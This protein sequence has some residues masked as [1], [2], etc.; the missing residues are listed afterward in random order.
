MTIENAGDQTN[1]DHIK[2]ATQENT[3]EDQEI[4]QLIFK[5]A[6]DRTEIKIL[7]L[8]NI[9]V[10]FKK[11]LNGSFYDR[12]I[13]TDFYNL[14]SY[15]QE[16]IYSIQKVLQAAQTILLIF[17]LYGQE[18]LLYL[19][20]H[21]QYLNYIPTFKEILD[22]TIE[23]KRYFSMYLLHHFIMKGADFEE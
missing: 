12:Y 22:F 4:N 10:Y 2:F 16:F 3:K 20:Q 9:A 15:S 23:A 1:P 19:N 17:G 21:E 8:F 18:C 6:K 7:D 13:T 11:N 5:F 14:K